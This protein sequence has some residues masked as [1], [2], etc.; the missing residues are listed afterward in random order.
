V[1][2]FQVL[3]REPAQRAHHFL[4]GLGADQPGDLA[5]QQVTESLV[6]MP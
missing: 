1:H 6:K 5:D 4:Q 2:A 3:G